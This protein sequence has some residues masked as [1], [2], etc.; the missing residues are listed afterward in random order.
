MCKYNKISHLELKCEFEDELRKESKPKLR[1]CSEKQSKKESE[2]KS[3]KDSEEKSRKESEAKD[4]K[5]SDEKADKNSSNKTS[6]AKNEFQEIKNYRKEVS[7]MNIFKR[8]KIAIDKYNNFVDNN[9]KKEDNENIKDKYIK[10]MSLL[11][12]DNTNKDIVKLY[13]NFIKSNSNFTKENKLL[14]YEIEINNYKI[15][16]TIDEMKQ[17]EKDIKKKSQKDIFLDYILSLSKKVEGKINF[18]IG[19]SI[20]DS[21][22]KELNNLFLFNTPIEFDNEELIYYK[23]YYNI[24]YETSKQKDEEIEDYLENKNN[25]IKYILKK[26][27]YNNKDIIY[28]KD[29]MNL[30]NIYLLKEKISN[31]SKEEGTVNFNRL[32]Q[33]LPVTIKDFQELAKKTKNKKNILHKQYQK[34]FIE[35]KY[36]YAKNDNNSF[37]NKM[38]KNNPKR[39]KYLWKESISSEYS[40]N[41]NLVISL[42]NACI[43]NLFDS[44]L[45][46]IID[47]KMFYNLNKLMNDNDLTPYVC[48]IKKFLKTIVDKKVYQQAIKKLFPNDYNSLISNNNEEIKQYIDER[49]K[50]YPFQNLDLSGITDKLSCYSFIPS[51]NF[52]LTE[53]EKEE[54]L[55]DYFKINEKKENKEIYIVGLTIV[56]SIHEVNHANQAIIFFKGNDKTLIDSPERI[57][58][59]NIPLSEG[60]IS[61]EFLLFGDVLERPNLF[62]CLYILNEKNY[63]QELDEFREN[64][65]KIVDIVKETKGETEFIKIENGIFKNLYEKAIAEIKQLI[66]DLDNNSI[67]TLPQ[68]YIEKSKFPKNNLKCIIRHKCAV[69]GGYKPH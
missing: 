55:D 25:V 24:I 63:D 60:G 57:I 4:E 5:M 58:K 2:E 51:I 52:R 34:Y 66:N 14:P 26:D 9:I 29:K 22:T 56:N 1:K 15:I 39:K 47:V 28:N 44:R 10:I 20:K 35:H 13:L 67:L 12:I 38:K 50:F 48:D 7:K 11:L 18:E 6:F 19:K 32:I 59:D 42:E 41:V 23:N 40:L 8:K 68:I 36:K 62:E 54:E 16:F 53:S 69:F 31:D 45:E 3:K 49:I 46:K 27:L 64:F 37:E 17:I 43:Q 30:L 21:A 65:R 33:K 61:L